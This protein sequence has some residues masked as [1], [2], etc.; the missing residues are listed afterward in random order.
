MLGSKFLNMYASSDGL[1][2]VITFPAVGATVTSMDG[3]DQLPV[4]QPLVDKVVAASVDKLRGCHVAPILFWMVESQSGAATFELTIAAAKAGVANYPYLLAELDMAHRVAK[5]MLDVHAT[6]G[7]AVSDTLAGWLSNLGVSPE[8]TFKIY[9]PWNRKGVKDFKFSNADLAPIEFVPINPAPDAG[10]GGAGGAGGAAVQGML[11]QN[12]FDSSASVAGRYFGSELAYGQL[13]SKEYRGR[14]EMI[15]GSPLQLWVQPAMIEQL[16]KLCAAHLPDRIGS[17][18]S[19]FFSLPSSAGSSQLSSENIN[20]RR[21]AALVSLV[22]EVKPDSRTSLVGAMHAF[23]AVMSCPTGHSQ[24]LGVPYTVAAATATFIN[25]TAV[26][27]NDML[28]WN[29]RTLHFSLDEA[30][31]F[32]ATV[33]VERIVV[34]AYETQD[35]TK[36]VELLAAVSNAA[37]LKELIVRFRD[38]TRTTNGSRRHSSAG[39]KRSSGA[40]GSDDSSS[41]GDEASG[42]PGSSSSSSSSKSGGKSSSGGASKKSK[43]TKV[44]YYFNESSCKDGDDCSF[45]HICSF[46]SHK[47]GKSHSHARIQCEVQKRAKDTTFKTPGPPNAKAL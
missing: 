27:L 7:V 16:I 11:P 32:I 8:E 35:E 23:A 2:K 25:A 39:G 45:E 1:G 31:A 6:L 40:A 46:C 36:C 14:I 4:T 22:S 15:F 38:S 33:L 29:D 44:C 3:K 12:P 18:A 5:L 10:A 43:P 13:K 17:D 20:F 19:K 9:R 26:A 21:Q 47:N 34:P 41:S 24:W 30:Y 42:R 37:D 28:H